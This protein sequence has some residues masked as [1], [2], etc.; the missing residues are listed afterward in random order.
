MQN[1]WSAL[2]ELLPEGRDK[3][4]WSFSHKHK[5]QNQFLLQ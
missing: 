3:L 5:L 2:G 1:S 4:F